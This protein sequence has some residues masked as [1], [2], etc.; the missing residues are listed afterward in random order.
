MS[1]N[2]ITDVSENDVATTCNHCIFVLTALPQHM[3]VCTHTHA[4]NMNV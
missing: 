1:S 4:H 3:H 2:G